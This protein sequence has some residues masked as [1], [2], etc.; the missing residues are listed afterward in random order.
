L[1][2]RIER[3]EDALLETIND[4]QD[5]VTSMPWPEK[6]AVT[7]DPAAFADLP[8]EIGLRLLG[9]AIAFAGDEGPVELAKLEALYTALYG[10]LTEAMLGLQGRARFR[11]TLAGAVVTLKGDQMTVERAPPRSG[12]RGKA[13]ESA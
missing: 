6:G 3:V 12:G 10:P 5:R 11:R 4:A 8:Q 13:G 9:R 1:A 2:R 7:M